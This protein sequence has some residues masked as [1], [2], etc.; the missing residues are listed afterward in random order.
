MLAAIKTMDDHLKM[1]DETIASMKVEHEEYLA[2]RKS[3]HEQMQEINARMLVLTEENATLRARSDLSPILDQLR[4]QG[5]VTMQILTTMSD[6]TK[7]VEHLADK[8]A[9]VCHLRGG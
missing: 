8:V 6:L 9:E 5:T 7:T 4:T 1:K 3:H 2:Y